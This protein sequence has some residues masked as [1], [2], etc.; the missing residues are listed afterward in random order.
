MP[1]KKPGPE[2]I[3][4][5]I[6]VS[7]GLLDVELAKSQGMG[8]PVDIQFLVMNASTADRMGLYESGP[9]LGDLMLC[10]TRSS[11]FDFLGTKDEKI[12]LLS[13]PLR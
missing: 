7:G 11:G 13:A 4:S 1:F 5:R 12:M 2:L 8:K 6:D 3:A 9:E 10:F